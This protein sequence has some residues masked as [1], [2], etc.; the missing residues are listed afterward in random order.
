LEEEEEDIPVSS[1]QKVN[2]VIGLK[3]V[4]TVHFVIRILFLI[5]AHAFFN[6]IHSC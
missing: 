5:I 4:P 3:Q 1:A 2:A 6:M